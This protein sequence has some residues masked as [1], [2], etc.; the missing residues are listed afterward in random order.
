[1]GDSGPRRT[2]GSLSLVRQ[3]DRLARRADADARDD[4]DGRQASRVESVARRLDEERTLGVGER[5]GLGGRAVDDETDAGAGNAHDVLGEGGEV[6]RIS[7]DQMRGRR[8]GPGSSEASKM[9]M[10]GA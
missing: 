1:M 9:E 10:T 2:T 8:G 4:G 5:D 6:C 3:F 7:V